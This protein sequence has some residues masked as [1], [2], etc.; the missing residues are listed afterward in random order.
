[1][2]KVVLSKAGFR[3]KKLYFEIT[4]LLSS[5]VASLRLIPLPY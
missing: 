3:L 1:M 2:L 4:K 5:D